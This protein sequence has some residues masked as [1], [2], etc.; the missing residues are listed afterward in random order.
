M[1]GVGGEALIQYR[2]DS[3]DQLGRHLHV[4]GDSTLL[5]V[6]DEKGDLHPGRVLVELQLRLPITTV[7]VRGQVIGRSAAPFLGAWIQMDS[8]LARHLQRHGT[9][10][11]RRERRIGTH[12]MLQLSG[13]SELLVE[14]VDVS[15]G[16][17]RV[18]GAQL[19]LSDS[20]SVRLLGFK[21]V[22]GDLGEARVVHVGGGESGLRFVERGNP[23]VLGFLARAESAW[24]GARRVEHPRNCCVYGPPVEPA[25]PKLHAFS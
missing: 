23:R 8:R 13:P 24:A 21:R 11:A 16:G 10:T 7:T 12:Q 14:L 9:L 15:R 2:F 3:V 22:E 19:G 25:T 4:T 6:R 17:L 1:T 18:R 20:Y 5:F